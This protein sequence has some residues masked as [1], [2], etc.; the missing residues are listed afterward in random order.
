[1]I[2]LGVCSVIFPTFLCV[3]AETEEVEFADIRREAERGSNF[4]QTEASSREASLQ[5][6]SC[7]SRECILS[8]LVSSTDAVWLLLT[9][10]GMSA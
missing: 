7:L 4:L 1:M 5:V 6:L 3:T 10:T 9:I 2:S 8:I